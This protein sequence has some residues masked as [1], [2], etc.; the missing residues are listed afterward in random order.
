M[1]R[2]TLIKVYNDD[3]FIF[4]GSLRKFLVENQNDPD[5]IDIT[6]DLTKVNKVTFPAFSGFWTIEKVN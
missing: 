2:Q 5:L 6:N 1:K 3:Q 4:F